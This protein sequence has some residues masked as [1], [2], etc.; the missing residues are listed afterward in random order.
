MN[1]SGTVSLTA[2]GLCLAMG[3]SPAIAK[4]KKESQPLE[5]YSARVI[6]QGQMGVSGTAQVQ[7]VVNRWST[8]EERQKVLN[9]TTDKDERSVAEA[10]ASLE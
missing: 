6:A 8:D 7:I 3:A 1:R 9:A 5:S 10:L 2:I 4:K